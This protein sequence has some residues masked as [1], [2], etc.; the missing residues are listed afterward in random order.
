MTDDAKFWDKAAAKYAASPIK[1]QAAYEFTLERTKSYLSQDSSVLEIGCGTGSTGVQLAP[2][3]GQYLG[4]DISEEMISIARAK[5][6]ADN[7]SNAA[8]DV[9]SV[10]AAIAGTWPVDVV[11]AFSILHL[12]RDL[13]KALQGIH[14]RLPGGGLLISKTPC[15]GS[16]GLAM[17]GVLRLILPAMQMLGK[18]PFVRSL[19][20]AELERVIEDAGFEIVETVPSPKGAHHYV[21]ARKR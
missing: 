13:E 15:L 9:S 19:T 10:A 21:V 4:T 12:V 7:L 3:A 17:R 2:V 14:S 5:A 1:D 16:M 8:F 11:C 18:A 6:A 20:V